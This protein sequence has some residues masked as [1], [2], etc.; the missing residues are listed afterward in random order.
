M[1]LRASG[2]AISRNT[3]DRDAP[4]ILA[5]SSSSRGTCAKL[6]RVSTMNSGSIRPVCAST[7]ARRG[8]A[9]R[10]S[11]LKATKIGVTSSDGGS[12]CNS[13]T[14]NNAP[15]AM[16]SLRRDSTKAPPVPRSTVSN[17]APAAIRQE[18][19]R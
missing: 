8:V 5:A 9:S 16:R 18:F 14:R 7:T 4:S 3:F 17:V 11:W 12:A 2:T 19:H 13:N 10:P 1:P 6:G 15:S